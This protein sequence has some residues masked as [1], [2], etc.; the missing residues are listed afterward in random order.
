[1]IPT[2]ASFQSIGS[3]KRG[4]LIGGLA[5]LV[6]AS[7]VTIY[8]VLSP[9]V[10]LSGSLGA[11]FGI[12]TLFAL[13][14]IG[15]PILLWIRYD[16]RSPAVLMAFILL[17]W[18]VLIHLPIFGSEGGDAPAFALVLFW[19]PVYLVAYA[20]VGGGEYWLRQRDS[21]RSMPSV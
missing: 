2:N 21:S 1:M 8:S 7:I 19:A 13:G 5:S 16:I 3:W 9:N 18:H 15:L 11:S 20:L 12:A 10:S 17:F 14:T 6:Y 4:V